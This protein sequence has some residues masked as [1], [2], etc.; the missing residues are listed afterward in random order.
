MEYQKGRKRGDH[1]HCINRD[2]SKIKKQKVFN[3]NQAKM[4]S[5]NIRIRPLINNFSNQKIK[6]RKYPKPINIKCP[7]FKKNNFI[8]SEE[9]IEKCNKVYHYM[10]YQV[11]CILEGET[12]TSKS[13]TASM[14]AKYR[15]WQIIEDEKE[16]ERKSGIKKRE[17]TEFKFYKFSLSKETKISDLFGKYS[18]SSDSL[19][20]IT[21]TNGPFIEAFNSGQGHCLLLDE[22]NLAPISVL[23]CIEEA[24]DTGILSIEIS[25]L[26][27]Q[28]FEMKPNF[29]LI[30]TQNK[31]TKFYKDKRESAGIKFLSKFQIVNFEELSR[32]EL[33][34]IAKGLRNNLSEEKKEG[35]IISDEDISKLIDFHIEWNKSKENDFICFTI[36]QINSCIEA[37]S[38]GEDMYNIIYNIYGKTHDQLEKFENIIQKYFQKKDIILDIP[39]DFP[40]CFKTT[41]IQKVFHQV[42]FAFNNGSNVII[43]GKKDVEKLNLLYIW[44]NIII[45]NI[46]IILKKKI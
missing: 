4:I 27:L 6:D 45:K 21:M 13:F 34:K 38:K 46:L 32:E 1:I 41:S 20:G 9:A 40:N 10:I 19:D 31:R 25:G 39:K 37:Y 28:R 12:G 22:I 26:P 7:L 8:L 2:N 15:Q 23:Q 5:E 36:R 35:I 33:I 3:E 44:Q 17:Y 43:T 18:G 14:M 11:P 16:E 42:D 30:A 29:C 24:I